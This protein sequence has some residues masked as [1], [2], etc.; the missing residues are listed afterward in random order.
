MTAPQP[1]TPVAATPAPSEATTEAPDDKKIGDAQSYSHLVNTRLGQRERSILLG[2]N[3]EEWT[4]L[5]E[6]KCDQRKGK[7]ALSRVIAKLVRLGLVES[8]FDRVFGVRSSMRRD[9]DG[10]E[11]NYN[12]YYDRTRKLRLTRCGAA[13]V[14]QFRDAL[15]SGQRI[16]WSRFLART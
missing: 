8:D 13:V 15:V 7:S 6:W 4:P 9:K 11:K 14:N 3:G 5:A 10:V 1:E 2:I 16:R 12:I